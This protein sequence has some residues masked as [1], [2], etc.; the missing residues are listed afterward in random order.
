MKTHI[1]TIDIRASLSS[2]ANKMLEGYMYINDLPSKALAIN[3][4][5]EELDI[6]DDLKEWLDREV[7]E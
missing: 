3:K 5:L 6:K 7:E 4:I 2:K 1:N